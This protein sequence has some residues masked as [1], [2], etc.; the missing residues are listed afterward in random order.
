MMSNATEN[1]VL[2]IANLIT[3]LAREPAMPEELL[4]RLL[5]RLDATPTDPA[6]YYLLHPTIFAYLTYLESIGALKHEIDEGRSLWG[7]T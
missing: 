3:E 4:A 1:L 5:M 2:E 7:M 6:S